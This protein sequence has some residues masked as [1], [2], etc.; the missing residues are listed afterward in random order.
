MD[1][2]EPAPVTLLDHLVEQVHL[3]PLKEREQDIAKYIL[4]CLDDAGYLACDLES[5]AEEF[6]TDISTI[7]RILNV[8]QTFDRPGIAAR[9]L[10][11][12]LLIQLN[13]ESEPD[14]NALRMVMD[15]FEDFTNKRFE[16]IAKRL[17]V[18]LAI[19]ELSQNRQDLLR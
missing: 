6:E 18:D 3:S 8:I 1:R 4:W 9:S 15:C 2:P 7:E 16:K 13:M 14:I 17:E 12:C 5:I 19:L 10:Q 11:E